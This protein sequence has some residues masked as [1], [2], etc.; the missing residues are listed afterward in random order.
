MSLMLSEIETID[1]MLMWLQST[2]YVAWTEK[3]SPEPKG[4]H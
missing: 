2:G 1:Q 4:P 3:D